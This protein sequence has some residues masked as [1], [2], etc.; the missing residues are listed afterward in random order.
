MGFS[1]PKNTGKTEIEHLEMSTATPPTGTS[2]PETKT[3]V[4]MKFECKFEYNQKKKKMLEML[5]W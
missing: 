1:S 3:S 2:M 4:M 5:M